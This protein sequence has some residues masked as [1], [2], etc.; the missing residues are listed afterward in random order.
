M[1]CETGAPNPQTPR[2]NVFLSRKN[3]ARWFFVR[4]P[5]DTRIRRYVLYNSPTGVQKQGAP[6]FPERFYPH[7]VTQGPLG[8]RENLGADW[9]WIVIPL[10]A[11]G[12]YFVTPPRGV[13]PKT[14]GGFLC[15]PG[16]KNCPGRFFGNEYQ[17]KP[18]SWMVAVHPVNP[19]GIN[20]TRLSQFEACT[21]ET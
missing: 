1:V 19:L 9:W 14:K 7:R 4:R 10:A 6:I 17:R 13:S 20:S 8:I 2:T 3:D 11:Q 12:L 18:L 21:K 15:G 5:R 16:L